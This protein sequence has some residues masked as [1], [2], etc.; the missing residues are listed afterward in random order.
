MSLVSDLLLLFAFRQT[1]ISP[2]LS[3]AYGGSCRLALRR[4]GIVQRT[5]RWWSAANY[6]SVVVIAAC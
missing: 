1:V 2:G 4:E 5:S 6:G 3:R